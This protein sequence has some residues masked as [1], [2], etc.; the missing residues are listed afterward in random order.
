MRED[1]LTKLGYK[2]TPIDEI[3]RI[4]NA[5]LR[6][7]TLEDFAIDPVPYTTTDEF[8][9]FLRAINDLGLTDQA[10][11]RVIPYSTLRS[12][13]DFTAAF[14]MD[15]VWRWNPDTKQ[16]EGYFGSEEAKQA[17]RAW[18]NLYND[19][20]ELLD[21]DY[22]I[23]EMAQIQEKIATGRVAVFDSQVDVTATDIS[24][25]SIDPTW[26][27]R[28]LPLPA[29]SERFGYTQTTTP[30]RCALINKDMKEDIVIRFLKMWEFMNTTEGLTITCFGPPGELTEISADGKMM[31][32]EPLMSLVLE[33]KT[34][35]PGGPDELGVVGLPGTYMRYGDYWSRVAYTSG[36]PRHRFTVGI[37]RS[38]DPIIDVLA[39]GRRF[40]CEPRVAKDPDAAFPRGELANMPSSYMGSFNTSDMSMLLNAKTD[41]EF[42]AVWDYV[43][44][45]NESVG[46]YSAAQKEMTAYFNSIGYN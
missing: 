8:V 11:N 39:Q 42:D 13:G 4:C 33:N 21:P 38:F 30:F 40:M 22:L 26:S 20:D 32:K 36:A 28:P 34:D 10:G 1:I 2:F 7:P 41:A 16:A 3:S 17:Y 23:H 35:L 9:E 15:Y 43:M 37:D 6:A 18:V 29:N 12:N 14:K 46:Q 19:P 27:I 31:F 5:E 25:K 24:L 45:Q 44:E